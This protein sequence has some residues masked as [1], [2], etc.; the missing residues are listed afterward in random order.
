MQAPDAGLDLQRTRF[1]RFG[2]VAVIALNHEK[3]LNAWSPVMEAEVRR[4]MLHSAQDPEVRVIVL[5]GEGSAFCAGADVQALREIGDDPARAEPPPVR[6]GDF[7][8][9]Y[10][11]LLGIPKPIVCAL[12][13]GAAGIGFVLAMFC[14]LRWAAQGAKLAPVFSRR[15]LVA[16]AGVAWI[17]SR[18]VGAAVALE[19]LLPGRTVSAE[20]ALQLRVV[21]DVLPSEGFRGE[22]IRRAQQLAA[23]VSPRAVG[24]I[25]RQVYEGLSHSLALAVA[26]AERELMASFST[27]DFQEGVAH[28]LEKRPPRFTGR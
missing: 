16:E 15:G 11:Y 13:G 6:A 4:L 10:T 27:E 20:E 23:S 18:L 25:K 3:R 26:E 8:Q 12:N 19:L 7:E 5:T 21:H 24:L 28:Y 14:D 9:R 2:H 22:V 1:E 17:L